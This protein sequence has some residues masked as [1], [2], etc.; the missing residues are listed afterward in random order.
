MIIGVAALAA[1]ERIVFL[2]KDALTDA[3]FDG[4]A[5]VSPVAVV[6]DLPPYC[7]GSRSKRKRL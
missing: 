5:I 1:N 7:S 3:E 6:I 4:S 2:A